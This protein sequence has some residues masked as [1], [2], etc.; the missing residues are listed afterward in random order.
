MPHSLESAEP[1]HEAGGGPA[2][3]LS[4]VKILLVD[5]DQ[6][7]VDAL[8]LRLKLAGFTRVPAFSLPDAIQRFERERPNLAVRDVELGPW[9]GLAL[10]KELRKRSQLPILMLTGLASE[11]ADGRCSGSCRSSR[12]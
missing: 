11:S 7:L 4:S 8:A 5:D 3:A 2:A 9:S 12:R 6:D 1:D 10:L